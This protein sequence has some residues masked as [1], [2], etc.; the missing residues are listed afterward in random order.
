MTDGRGIPV[1]TF[2]QI[3][4]TVSSPTCLYPENFAWIPHLVPQHIP[5]FSLY[6]LHP[7][8]DSGPNVPA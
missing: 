6:S 7:T 1:P 3:Q 2:A 4:S 5:S 8:V